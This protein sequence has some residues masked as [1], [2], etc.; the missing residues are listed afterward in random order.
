MHRGRN[1]LGEKP[2]RV[3]PRG[4]HL[5]GEKTVWHIKRNSRGNL[6]VLSIREDGHFPGGGNYEF[7][8]LKIYAEMK[9]SSRKL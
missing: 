6:N 1:G 3:F 5:S 2:S 9:S 4:T 8:K 7:D